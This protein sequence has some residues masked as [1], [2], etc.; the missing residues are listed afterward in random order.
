MKSSAGRP[1][2]IARRRGFV[3]CLSLACQPVRRW[4]NVRRVWLRAGCGPLDP[5]GEVFPRHHRAKRAEVAEG[6]TWTVGAPVPPRP[7]TIPKLALGTEKAAVRWLARRLRS[8]CLSGP[9][10]PHHHE[11][12]EAYRVGALAHSR[13]RGVHGAVSCRRSCCGVT[14]LAPLGAQTR[15][16]GGFPTCCGS[17]LAK[18]PCT[19]CWGSSVD[20]DGQIRPDLSWLTACHRA[21]IHSDPGTEIPQWGRRSRRPAFRQSAIPPF[22]DRHLV[23]TSSS[24]RPPRGP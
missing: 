2:R 18:R 3:M 1:D 5:G 7:P 20:P 13:P 11:H 12:G 17:A 9:L 15:T 24:D 6:R 4:R 8:A 14:A 23:S 19:R 16:W 21:T 22:S 10:V